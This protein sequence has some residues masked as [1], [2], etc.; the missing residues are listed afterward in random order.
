MERSERSRF[1]LRNRFTLIELLIVIAIIAILAGMLLPALNSARNKAREAL[2]MGNM[3]Q[4][5]TAI[6]N[7][8][9]DSDDMLPAV[10]NH[11]N[12]Y[13]REFFHRY[14]GIAEYETAQKGV[15]FCPTHD[16]V[17]PVNADTK[18]Y[19]SYQPLLS[20]V[21]NNTPGFSWYTM[22]WN[23]S[24]GEQLK[25]SRI[26]ALSSGVALMTSWTPEYV[27]W[28]NAI[29]CQDPIRETKFNTTG[30]IIAPE[31]LQK[32]L[33][34]HSGRTNFLQTSGNVTSRGSSMRLSW[35]TI[36]GAS[37]WSFDLNLAK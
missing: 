5:G 23:E 17:P 35:A 13:F 21:K 36:R 2:C 34:I 12:S 24:G 22:A 9:G 27:S 10:M 1:T 15:L 14:L 31:I 19:S 6:A 18:Y 25:G 37:A 28:K 7:Y 29:A 3:K 11:S 4:I 20:S 8:V 30:N 26:T 33:F 32:D 16:I